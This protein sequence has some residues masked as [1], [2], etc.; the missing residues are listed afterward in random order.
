MWDKNYHVNLDRKVTLIRARTR[1]DLNDIELDNLF[2]F[3]SILDAIDPQHDITKY[4]TLRN[5]PIIQIL[6]TLPCSSF[7]LSF[8]LFFFLS[9]FFLTFP[10]ITSP[11]NTIKEAVNPISSTEKSCHRA[12]TAPASCFG[13]SPFLGLC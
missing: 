6:N 13:R 7:F 8:F 3:I 5:K 11:T 10:T 1:S 4:I 12:S 9:Y 2:T